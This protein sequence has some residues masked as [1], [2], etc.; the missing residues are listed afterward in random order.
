MKRKFKAR[1]IWFTTL[2]AAIA[3]V[4]III[5]PALTD[6]SYLKPGIEAR[7]GNNAKISGP[8][9]IILAPRPVLR[10]HDLEIRSDMIKAKADSVQ[11]PIRLRYLFQPNMISVPD[12]V[13]VRE[14]TASIRGQT[15]ASIN[16]RASLN[17]KAFRGSFQHQGR[18]Y[19]ANI[20]DGIAIIEAPSLSLKTK[21]E[22]RII[23]NSIEAKGQFNGSFPNLEEWINGFGFSFGE[24]AARPWAISTDFVCGMAGLEFNSMSL[25]A[26][27]AILTGS[28]SVPHHGADKINIMVTEGNLDELYSTDLAKKILRVEGEGKFKFRGRDVRRVLIETNQDEITRAEF[29]GDGFQLRARGHIIDGVPHGLLISLHKVNAQDIIGI[30]EPASFRCT[31]TGKFRSDNW[32]CD[33]LS[34]TTQAWRISGNA[35]FL[36]GRDHSPDDLLIS[37]KDYSGSDKSGIIKSLG[38]N[39]NIKPGT[40]LFIIFPG[41]NPTIFERTGDQK[42]FSSE[43]AR[44]R[45]IPFSMPII[46]K[47][48]S[49]LRERLR[50]HTLAFISEPVYSEGKVA[51][52]IPEKLQIGRK[53]EGL[54][55]QLATEHFH[56][57]GRNLARAIPLIWGGF[58]SGFIMQDLPFAATR[59]RNSINMQF[60]IGDQ[61]ITGPAND[62]RTANLDLDKIISPAWRTDYERLQFLHNDPIAALFRIDKDFSITAD[63]VTFKGREYGNMI[64]SKTG[65]VQRISVTDGSNGQLLI[66][67]QRRG[68]ADYTISVKASRFQIPGFLNRFAGIDIGN[69]Q[70]SGEALIT[71]FGLIAHDIWNNMEGTADLNFEGGTVRGIDTRAIFN[72]SISRGNLV[73]FVNAAFAPN[74]QMPIRIMNIPVRI[75]GSEITS[76][77]PFQLRS[78]NASISGW[79]GTEDTSISVLFRNATVN[80]APLD[81]ILT[82]TGPT[83]DL[84]SASRSINP[85]YIRA[86]LNR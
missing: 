58:D 86:M 15:F 37:I 67:I 50:G 61:T 42:R 36:G 31:L 16:G 14:G 76:A 65:N 29:I 73:D 18:R 68:G 74:A 41:E 10:A 26:S 22:Y 64:Y 33:D 21:A 25:F 66:E 30:A 20:K 2:V 71:T 9:K 7:I 11:F 32:K 56:F 80:P 81:V 78:D 84:D 57:Q 8:V 34:I 62:L 5:F 19:I 60:D 82:K 63:R 72:P 39:A 3:A 52:V 12:A 24:S 77:A 4:G 44:I 45:D 53:D 48:P 47:I 83:F 75:N 69:T 46:D 51:E 54:Y 17:G 49:A 6:F 23:G 55:L 85:D 35:V 79:I 59:I 38:G 1:I 13:S 27:D 28:M 43:N 70:L 40:R